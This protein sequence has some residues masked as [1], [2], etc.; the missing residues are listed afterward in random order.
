MILKIDRF[1]KKSL[2]LKLHNI[3]LTQRKNKHGIF[4]GKVRPTG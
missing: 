1:G 4:L 2:I 3:V